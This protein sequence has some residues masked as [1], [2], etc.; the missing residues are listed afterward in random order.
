MAHAAAG[1]RNAA[2]AFHYAERVRAAE[3]ADWGEHALSYV[4]G[5]GAG[6]GIGYYMFRALGTGR[7]Y[8]PL[9]ARSS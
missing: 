4:L 8:L 1:D 7:C 2:D 5:W 3:S 6:Y 9:L